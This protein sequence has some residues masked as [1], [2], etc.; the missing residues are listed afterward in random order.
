MTHPFTKLVLVHWPKLVPLL[1]ANLGKRI[2]LATVEATAEVTN[3]L[4]AV[5]LAKIEE[6][7]VVTLGTA[8]YHCDGDDAVVYGELSAEPRPTQWVCPSC[9]VVPYA[10]ELR[11]GLFALVTDD[12]TKI[13]YFLEI[14][15]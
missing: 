15:T 6:R 1:K 13:D 3:V 5:I 10:R 8:V 7:G 9:K 4:A 11:Y 12:A 2:S 14:G